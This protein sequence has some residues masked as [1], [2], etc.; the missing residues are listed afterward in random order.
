MKQGS[1]KSI[2]ARLKNIADKENIPF[3]LILT[4]YFHERLLYRI[5]IS[6]YVGN[7]FLK[8][9]LLLYAFEGLHTRPTKDIDMLVKHIDND[10]DN[11]KSICA[12]ICRINHPEDCAAFDATSLSISDITEDAKYRGVRVLLEA[13]LD[14]IRQVLQIDFGFSDNIYAPIELAFPVL[15][16]EF[17][18]PHIKAYSLETVIAEKFHAMIALGTNN[19]RMKDFYDVYFLLKNNTIADE[20]LHNAIQAT[21][22]NRNTP[23]SEHPELFSD[24]FHTNKNRQAMWNAFLRKIRADSPDFESIVRYITE[25]LSQF[26]KHSGSQDFTLTCL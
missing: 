3:Q 26:H 13:G 5:S 10:K 7:F 1:P 24:S 14:T 9:G 19:S 18:V 15:M 17:D 4:R 16:E 6:E 25:R 20:A 23:Y 12:E 21:F 11:I 8:G 2:R 22:Q